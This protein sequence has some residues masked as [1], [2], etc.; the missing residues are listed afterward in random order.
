MSSTQT[1]LLGTVNKLQ[2]DKYKHY[3]FN[4]PQCT[5][6]EPIPYPGGTRTTAWE[7]LT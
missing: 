6:S 5:L 7:T 3:V 4:V 2:F 1:V